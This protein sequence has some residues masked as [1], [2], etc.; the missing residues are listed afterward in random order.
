[1]RVDV[2]NTGDRVG[3]E[4]VQLY[5][6]DLVSSVTRPVKELKGFQRVALRPRETMTVSLPI[7]P[8]RLAFWNIDMEYVV[9]PGEFLIMVGPNSQDLQSVPLSVE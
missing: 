6:R 7:T 9:E 4:V 5:V 2:T 1:V 3:E 8:D